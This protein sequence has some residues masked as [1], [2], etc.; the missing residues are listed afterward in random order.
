MFDVEG[1]GGRLTIILEEELLLGFPEFVGVVEKSLFD[2]CSHYI[3]LISACRS[4]DE[5]CKTTRELAVLIGSD[6]PQTKET[7]PTP[8]K[9][10]RNMSEHCKHI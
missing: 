4:L 3:C 8:H 7:D 10:R 1:N 2:R 5:Q 9:N 6:I